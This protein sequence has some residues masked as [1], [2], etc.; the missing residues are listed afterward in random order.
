MKGGICTREKC[1]QCGGK[2][3]EVLSKSR[4][5]PIMDMI[6]PR[7]GTTPRRFFLF[8]YLSKQIAPDV[9]KRKVRLYSNQDGYPLGSYGEAHR[10]LEQIRSEIDARIFDISNYL[11]SEI[12]GFRGAR[13]FPRWLATKQNFSPT[14]YRELKRYVRLYFG[15]YFD[16]LD[17]RRL[18]TAHIEDFLEWIP[19]RQAELGRPDLSP[20]TKKN[21]MGALSS[22]ARW[23]HRR[24]TIA[25]LPQFPAI[26]VPD[27]VIQWI[28]KED[29]MRILE[30]IPQQHR[31][32][33]RFMA[34]HPVRSGEA[35]ALKVKDFDPETITVHV[36]RAFSGGELRS[37]KNRRDYYLPLSETF[38]WSLLA[39][40]L[41]EAWVF[42]TPRGRPYSRD[43]LPKIWR[44]S[45][46]RAGIPH[47]AL[48]N[49]TR[50]SVASQAINR[51]VRIEA[52]SRA[53]GHSNIGVTLE[54]YA[55]LE[56]ES[57]REVLDAKV[58]VS[59]IREK[60]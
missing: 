37:R 28:G 13:Q 33:F 42:T 44:D 10:L 29:Q 49:A 11:P 27:P 36:S 56:V 34:W 54:R 9:A 26:P 50:H 25:Q 24:G 39:G 40:K 12:E 20:K 53:L 21:I 57:L 46:H 6:C 23:L 16:R 52:V 60:T 17:T 15:P 18:N 4:G 47:I 1:P 30:A 2:F 43:Y 5:K 32:I 59:L 31:A 14:H 22:F 19:V 48:K 35:R 45:L 55:K 41:P 51:G 8:L 38:D 58:V 7:C 3:Q